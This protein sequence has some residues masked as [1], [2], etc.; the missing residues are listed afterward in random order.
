MNHR[1]KYKMKLYTI[2]R[3][4][5]RSMWQRKSEWHWVCNKVLDTTPKSWSMKEKN[6]YSKLY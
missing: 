4:K 6:W 3:R 2:S 5:H 1:Y